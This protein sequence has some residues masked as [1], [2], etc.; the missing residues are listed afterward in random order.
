VAD[1]VNQV[2]GMARALPEG[3]FE[4]QFQQHFQGELGQL[5]SYLEAVRQTL[6]P[7]SVSANG[8]RELIPKAADMDQNLVDQLLATLR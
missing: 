1:S 4:D 6:L 5:A 2:I 7:L 8:S 3:E